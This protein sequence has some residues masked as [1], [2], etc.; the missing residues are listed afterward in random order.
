MRSPPKSRRWRR[1]RRLQSRQAELV[2]ARAQARRGAGE[3]Q[4]PRR[5][6]RRRRRRDPGRTRR[7][8]GRPRLG[9]ASG[10]PDLG[11]SGGLIWPVNGA[12][13]SGFGMRWG[14]CTRASTSPCR[15][16]RRSAPPPPAR[17]L[18]PVRRR[19]RRLRQLHLPRP[20]R[21]ALHLLRPPVLLRGRLGAVGSQGDVIGYVGCTGHCFGDLTCIS[22]FGSAAPRPIRSATSSNQLSAPHDS[23]GPHLPESG[24][25][26]AVRR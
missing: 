21:R 1:P 4:R 7:P 20:R 19:K 23:S 2:A 5:G 12:V 10:R 9:A 16:A 17:R 18:A 14:A 24:A 13:V 8:A 25:M 15:Q 3:D 6:A 26:G 11:G 22:R